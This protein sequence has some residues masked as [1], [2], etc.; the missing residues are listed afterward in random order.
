SSREAQTC[1]LAVL[2]QDDLVS[3]REVWCRI[4]RSAWWIARCASSRAF[5]Q[6]TSGRTTRART[7]L[8][9]LTQCLRTDEG[10]EA[11][12]P[13]ADREERFM[14]VLAPLVANPQATVLV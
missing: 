11:D 1:G 6:Q 12:E 13:A 14:D 2:A 8:E 10:L 3:R 5:S 4:S 7:S 9:L